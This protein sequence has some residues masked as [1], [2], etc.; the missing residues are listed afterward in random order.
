MSKTTNDAILLTLSA[1]VRNG[2]DEDWKKSQV[3]ILSI[4][5]TQTGSDVF[6][7]IKAAY[8]QAR[9]APVDPRALE[10]HRSLMEMLQSRVSHLQQQ[11]MKSPSLVSALPPTVPNTTTLCAATSCMQSW[12]NSLSP[13]WYIVIGIAV[14]LLLLFLIKKLWHAITSK[15]SDKTYMT[16][17][18]RRQIYSFSEDLSV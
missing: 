5:D 14:A 18:P 16:P 12:W 8:N 2:S 7:E 1:Y 11:S 10:R 3:A 6:D 4:G 17:T 13:L 15:N 9:N